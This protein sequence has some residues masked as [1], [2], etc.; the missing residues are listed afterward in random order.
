[1]LRL[2]YSN[3]NS[4]GFKGDLV[5]SSSGQYNSDKYGCYKAY[6]IVNLFVGSK[7]KSFFI[8][9]KPFGSIWIFS[10]YY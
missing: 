4:I 3:S 8:K 2:R 1:M 10:K 9:S 6:S 5:G 7:D